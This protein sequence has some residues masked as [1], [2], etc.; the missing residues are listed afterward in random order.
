VKADLVEFAGVPG[1]AILE[2]LL[3]LTGPE[4][5]DGI[6]VGIGEL[7]WLGNGSGVVRPAS[8]VRS[9][10]APIDQRER[11]KV[12]PLVAPRLAGSGWQLLGE[13]QAQD[14]WLGGIP[15]EGL[16]DRLGLD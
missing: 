15:A 3:G 4:R 13:V 10:D 8:A 2:P 6:T 12:G 16:G 5:D 7:V 1:G 14:L 9:L 11:L